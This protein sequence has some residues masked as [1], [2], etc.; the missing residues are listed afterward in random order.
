M[1]QPLRKTWSMFPR[2]IQ[3]RTA[4]DRTVLLLSTCPQELKRGILLRYLHGHHL[5][6]SITRNSQ[7]TGTNNSHQLMN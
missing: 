6:C 3:A 1:K 4:H 2:K 5:H 7:D